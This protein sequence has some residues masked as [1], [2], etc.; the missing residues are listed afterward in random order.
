MIERLTRILIAVPEMIEGLSTTRTI[1]KAVVSK[2]ERGWIAA[3]KTS[4]AMAAPE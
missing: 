4:D 2:E 1:L 3:S